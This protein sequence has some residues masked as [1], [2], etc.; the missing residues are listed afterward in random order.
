M[1]RRRSSPKA[2]VIVPRR[3]I[4]AAL[5]CST[6]MPPREPKPRTVT[7]VIVAD[8][9]QLASIIDELVHR[10]PGLD[11]QHQQIIA[12]QLRLHARVDRPTWEIYLSVEEL[13]N[14]RLAEALLVVARWA[15]EQGRRGV[16]AERGER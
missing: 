15:F 6:R 3:L 12:A 13:T 9:Q 14:A 2:S 1:S 7:G 4:G 11:R 16:A 8:P 10:H 5:A